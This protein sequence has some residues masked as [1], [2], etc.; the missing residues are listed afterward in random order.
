[1]KKIKRSALLVAI[2][3]SMFVSFMKPVNAFAGV[4]YYYQTVTIKGN[5]YQEWLKNFRARMNGFNLGRT[6]KVGYN[7]NM[8]SETKII[9][10]V[11]ALS[12]KTFK[13][14]MPAC[15]GPGA[16]M[17]YKKVKCPTKLKFKIHK[18]DMKNRHNAARFIT[19]LTMGYATFEQR[20][21]CGLTRYMYVELP[22]PPKRASV[23][24]IDMT[25]M[26]TTSAR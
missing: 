10:G 4:S 7:G 21:D 5:S 11:Q 13:V 24:T 19:C 22:Q 3:F 20:C 6:M 1:M 15:I 26:I 12:T 23:T 17:V 8:S 2:I 25:P 9:I 18:H 14:R 16:P